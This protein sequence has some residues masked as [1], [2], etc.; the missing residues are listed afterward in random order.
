[1]LAV[2]LGSWF[3]FSHLQTKYY[4]YDE[5]DGA[6]DAAGYSVAELSAYHPHRSIPAAEFVRTFQ[7]PGPGRGPADTVRVLASPDAAH[8]PLFYLLERGVEEAVGDS[9]AA[10]RLLAAIAG[11]LLLPAVFWLC[12]EVFDSPLAA[13]IAVAVV[14]LSPYQ[15]VFSQQVREYTLYELLAA[16]VV[17]LTVRGFRERSALIWLAYAIAVV[18]M[19]YCTVL[20]MFVLLSL[21]VY[22]LLRR[23]ALDLRSVAAF[24][25][26]T[27]GALIAFIPWLTTLVRHWHETATRAN[28]WFAIALPLKLYTAKLAFTV[29]SVFFDAE[30][31][32]VRLG[33]ILLPVA[34]AVLYAIWLF[35]SRATVGE[36]TLVA[37]LFGTTALG[38][39][40]TD[41]LL[42]ASRAVQPR[43]VVIA[44]LALEIAVA[45]GLALGLSRGSRGNRA[46]AA[47]ALAVILVAETAS[48]AIGSVQRSWWSNNEA[49]GVAVAAQRIAAD[50]NA[51]V[52][53]NSFIGLQ[54][55]DALPPHVL[56]AF[57][58]GDALSSGEPVLYAL[59][60]TP[61]TLG[62]LRSE[63]RSE[64]ESVAVVIAQ[65]EALRSIHAS[66]AAAHGLSGATTHTLW[67]FDN[68]AR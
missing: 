38:F 46:L 24:G 23:A 12:T 67:R 31:L 42:R 34:F 48:T 16:V 62:R 61:A 56:V 4:F 60:P 64:G 13:W 45:C 19:L 66:V 50:R 2:A 20:S 9:I 35:L 18:A 25:I 33:I 5:V 58:P 41:A 53:V 7:M 68:R 17:A 3:R 32:D 54:L 21:V 55:A 47:T 28:H 14:A 6:R 8:P 36:K 40:L 26:A 37:S 49:A 30:Y 29:S 57:D 27:V 11:V 22:V 15:V 63:E 51:V 43:Y 52:L 39:L 65:Q 59:D 1:V 10:R 44:S